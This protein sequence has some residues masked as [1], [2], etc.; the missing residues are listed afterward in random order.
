MKYYHITNRNLLNL[1]LEEFQEDYQDR[2]RVYIT[3]QSLL[4]D[5]TNEEIIELL[6]KR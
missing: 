6:W 1:T 4:T 3:E 5:L 2:D